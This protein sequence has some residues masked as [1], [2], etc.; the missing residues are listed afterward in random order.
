MLKDPIKQAKELSSDKKSNEKLELF[1]NI[2]DIEVNVLM[3]KRSN[4]SKQGQEISARRIFSF[5]KHINMVIVCRKT[6][7]FDSMK[8]YY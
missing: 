3:S 5:D 4:K 7:L 6:R 2:F 8:L 1:Q